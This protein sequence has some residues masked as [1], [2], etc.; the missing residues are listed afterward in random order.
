MEIKKLI[1]KL[2]IYPLLITLCFGMESHNNNLEGYSKKYKQ[3][4]SNK[5]DEFRSSAMDLMGED[6]TNPIHKMA[7][8]MLQSLSY[9][10]YISK[11]IISIDIYRVNNGYEIL[12]NMNKCRKLIN[13]ME[14][15]LHFVIPKTK[16]LEFQK[17]SIEET[18]DFFDE[19]I[20]QDKFFITY[21]QAHQL[22]TI[23]K[24]FF[25]S[26]CKLNDNEKEQLNNL[27]E[28]IK[29]IIN[30]SDFYHLYNKYKTNKENIIN[31]FINLLEQSNPDNI[32]IIKKIKYILE[33][34][35]KNFALGK[36]I[37][38]GR[39][40]EKNIKYH[41]KND[42]KILELLILLLRC[43][44]VREDNRSAKQSIFR[45]F[46]LSLMGQLRSIN[47]QENSSSFHNPSKFPPRKFLLRRQH[48]SKS[49]K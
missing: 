49:K 26:L 21:S 14:N 7:N 40:R 8:N 41:N 9:R 16:Y 3:K 48:Q 10:S 30:K 39:D 38:T 12:F 28:M 11:Q 45:K 18:I 4:I 23:K 44:N 47:R 33:N 24:N 13:K 35:R 31:N 36:S 15:A 37:R 2:M 46:L 6:F 25:Y 34:H 27:M 22:G 19:I 29:T 5:I 43:I 32:P 1:N 20:K 17:G 42:K